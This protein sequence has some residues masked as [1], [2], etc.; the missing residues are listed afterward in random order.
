MKRRIPLAL[1]GRALIGLTIAAF[2][3]VGF[4]QSSVE[5]DGIF[6][7]SLAKSKYNVGPAPKSRTINFQGEGQSA[8]IILV[9][10]E[11]DGNPIAIVFTEAVPDGKPHPVIGSPNYDAIA[12]TRVDA[13]TTNTRYIKAGKVVLT[14]TNV[15]SQDGKTFTVTSAD[16]DGRQINF[17]AVYEKQQVIEQR[18]R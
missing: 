4:A 12:G 6:Q 9:G 2:I 7:L 1:T 11:A 16:A 15:T 10:I 17:I 8:K 3:Q 14:S 18:Q 5:P 13:Y